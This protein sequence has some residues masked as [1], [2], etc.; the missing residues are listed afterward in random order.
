MNRER[1]RRFLLS[2]VVLLVASSDANAGDRTNIVGAGMGRTS[3]AMARGLD[4]V[5]MNPANLALDGDGSTVSI[6]LLPFGLHVGSDVLTYGLYQDYFTGVETDSGRFGRHLN[7][8]DKAR[9]LDAFSGTEGRILADAEARPLGIAVRPGEWGA[10]ALTMTERAAGFGQIPKDY[11]TFLFYGNP[12]GSVYDFSG[13]DLKAVWLEEFAISAGVQ[14]P[15]PPFVQA[16]AGGISL[17]LVRGLACAEIERFST[18]LMTAGNGVLDGSLDV[19]GR[20]SHIDA[21]GGPGAPDFEPFPA[22]AGTGWGIDLGVAAEIREGVSGALSL[23]DIGVVRWSRNVDE[24]V[25]S[26]VIHLDDPF[27]EGQRD[28]LEQAVQGRGR[29]GAEFS[30]SL[31]T[32]LRLGV[33]VE[34][35]TV[36]WVRRIL[37]GEMTVALDY[38]QGLV[39]APGTSVNPRISLG[40]EYRPVRFLPLRA[41]VALGGSDRSSLAFGLGVHAGFFRLDLASENIEWVFSGRSFSAASLA[42]GM[43][44][45]F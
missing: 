37:F 36:P 4:A 13:T 26:G 28:S 6:S 12:P 11:L 25:A 39:D 20:A 16:L 31:P 17:K 42:A 3:A 24:R 2:G 19:L 45:S 33:A 29:E 44:F 15:P 23:T 5:G 18:R 9:I 32:T 1:L 10:L 43:T 38:H 7:E 41:G 8:A 21:L 34:L 30:T 22:P 40:V 14:L 35:H 27:D